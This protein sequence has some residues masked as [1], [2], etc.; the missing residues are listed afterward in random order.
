MGTWQFIPDAEVSRALHDAVLKRLVDSVD[1]IQRGLCANGFPAGDA[2]LTERLGRG[3]SA[4]VFASYFELLPFV[5]ADD[6][7][8]ASSALQALA[9]FC[10]MPPPPF[11]SAWGD[12]GPGERALLLRRLSTDP[13]TAITLV[14]PSDAD[15][16]KAKESIAAALEIFDAAA[17]EI[18]AEIRSLIRE[19]ILV[20]GTVNNG[21]RFDG[22]TCF[23]TWGALFLNAEEH[24][25]TMDA[26]DGLSHECAHAYLFGQG[27]GEP[28]VTNPASERYRSPLREDARHLDG[29]FHA[30]FVSARMH[31]AHTKVLASALLSPEDRVAAEQRQAAGAAAFADG[32]ATLRRHA[33]MTDMGEALLRSAEIYMD[34]HR[35]A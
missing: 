34:R 2:G 20:A 1:E 3:A 7:A 28:F 30:T 29:I 32:R 24:G 21:L 19:I 25:T 33:T 5:M 10:K 12:L 23:A 6:G 8:A 4:C 18:S 27:F 22:A 35:P 14:P 31:Y 15:A 11:L 17:P 26:V 13:T 16:Q 9:D